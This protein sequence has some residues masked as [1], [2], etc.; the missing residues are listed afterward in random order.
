MIKKHTYGLVNRI[1]S[2][3]FVVMSIISIPV[4]WF[5]LYI[6]ITY[7]FVGREFALSSVL[8]AVGIFLACIAWSPPA[9]IFMAYLLTDIDADENGLSFQ[10]LWKKF[11]IPWG[12]VLSIKHIRPF[13]LFTNKHSHI[14]IV[15]SELTFIHRIYGRVYG[16]AYQSA[17][18]IHKNISNYDLLMKNI[19]NTWGVGEE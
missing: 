5:L 16:G 4:G 6:Y 10:F 13:G 9:F 12:E 2:Y 17:V 8:F 3:F 1:S 18:L 7:F 19:S 11:F 15:R 14:L